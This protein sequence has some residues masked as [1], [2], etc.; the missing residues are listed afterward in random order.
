MRSK[1]I[2]EKKKFKSEKNANDRVEKCVRN[3]TNKWKIIRISENETC[4]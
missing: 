2:R 3:G 1:K 4:I